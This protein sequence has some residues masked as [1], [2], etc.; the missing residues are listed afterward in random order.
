MQ[1]FKAKMVVKPGAKP[2]FCQPRSVL[3]ALHEAI[4]C[5]LDSLESEGVV[6][7]ISHSDWAAPII[8]VPKRDNAVRICG[9]YKGDC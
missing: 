6:E 4:K 2:Q 5:E 8:A 1:Q 9:D 7:R 3:Y